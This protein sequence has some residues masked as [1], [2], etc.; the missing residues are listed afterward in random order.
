MLFQLL[1]GLS[2]REHEHRDLPAFGLALH[3]IHHGQ[4]TRSS[5]DNQTTTFPWNLLFDGNW[6]VSELVA[7][8]FRGL[9]HT[10]THVPAFD[11]DVMFIGH[12]VDTDRTK[13]ELLEAHFDLPTEVCRIS[14]EET[15][16]RADQKIRVPEQKSIRGVTSLPPWRARTWSLLSICSDVP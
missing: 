10:L 16:E 11:D 15:R 3:I 12:A 1:D 8:F 14:V 6:R 4:A 2:S 5:A 13:G 9:L 7:K